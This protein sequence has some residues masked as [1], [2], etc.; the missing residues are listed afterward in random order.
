MINRINAVRKLLNKAALDA[1]VVINPGNR[2]Y[3]SGFTGTSGILFIDARRAIL[4]TDFRYREQAAAQ[5]PDYEIIT[6]TGLF[7]EKLLEFITPSKSYRLACEGDYIT[8]KQFIAIK[9]SLQD[10]TVHPVNEFV[11]ALRLV[12]D[13]TEINKIGRAVKIADDAFAN[14]LPLIKPGVSE[15]E[16]ALELEFFMRRAGAEKAA[17]TFIV[18]S[19]TR[20][21]MPHGVASE[22]LIKPGELLTMDFGAVYQGYHSDI[23]RTVLIGTSTA[24]QSEIYR[25]V[26]EAQIAALAAVRSGIKASEVDKAARDIIASYGYGEN[27]GHSTGHG[28]GLNI[29]ENPRLAAKDETILLPGM[30]V[31]IEPGIYIPDWGGVRIE[32]TVV[33]EENGCQILTRSPKMNL[34]EIF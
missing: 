32:D 15:I 25:I 20:S 1:I 14:I 26:L 5:A 21:S 17:F 6:F 7:T 13:N 22:K 28:L 9:E 34:M 8:Y 29:H 23:T 30:V 18:A 27:F 33:V 31:T 24:K 2:L 4:L 12:K 11:E 3:L 19:G 16:L 10:I